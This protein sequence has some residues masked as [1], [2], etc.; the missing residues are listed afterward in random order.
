M[1]ILDRYAGWAVLTTTLFGTG[2]LS[3]F[4]VLANINRT[5]LDLIVNQGLPWGSVLY[6]A[7][8][9]IPFTLPYTIPWGI[10]VA[11]LLIFGRL[12]A[13]GELVALRSCGLS[14]TRFCAPVFGL[15]LF[16]SALCLWINT[17][18]APLAQRKIFSSIRD[19]AVRNPAAL[20]PAGEVIDTFS[21]R[22]IYIGEKSGEKLVNISIFEMDEDGLLT[23]ALHAREGSLS[24]QTDGAGLLL[25]F[26]QARF[27]ERRKSADASILDVRPSLALAEGS[28]P[29]A[30]RDFQEATRR[31]NSLGARTQRELGDLI[32]AS[33]NPERQRLRLEYHRRFSIA[34]ASL[35]FPLIGVPLAVVAH[36]RETIAGFGISLVVAFAYYLSFVVVQSLKDHFQ[37]HPSALIWL[38]N[39]VFGIA[40]GI[41][42]F[43]L[44]RR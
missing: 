10:L 15:A 16:L 41:L 35:V 25:S 6:L 42:F 22:R 30:P 11:V 31:G 28:Y 39:L 26:R 34:L 19:L 5:L 29:L 36:R 21:G 24:G 8:L 33:E 17:D 44:T 27:E 14:I 20:L 18:L 43:R 37:W 4:L 23:R 3:F 38:P 32:A 40:G 7:L 2:V 13:D 12:S 1:K 9:F